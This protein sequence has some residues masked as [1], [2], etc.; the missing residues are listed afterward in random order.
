MVGEGL[1]DLDRPRRRRDRRRI[2]DADGEGT[3][4][5]G[6]E[7]DLPGEDE[8]RAIGWGDPAIERTEGL[9]VRGPLR[10]DAEIERPRCRHEPGGVVTGVPASE[11]A[12]E[13]GGLDR[14]I[15]VE[16]EGDRRER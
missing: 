7:G 4:Q 1:L 9:E 16:G 14:E 3:F 6:V 15:E 8:D 13:G 5:D 10:L 11:V 12:A 2:E